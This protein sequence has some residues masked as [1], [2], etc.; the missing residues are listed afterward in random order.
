[1][2][3]TKHE[4]NS[5]RV[6]Y[7]LSRFPKLTETFILYEILE[8]Q[9]QDGDV[10]VHAMV[11]EH[12]DAIHPEARRM[13]PG[14]DYPRAARLL[15]SQIEWMARRPLEYLGLWVSAVL[16]NLRSP[17]FLLRA[18]ATV[19]I[20]AYFASRMSNVRVAHVHAHW[21]THS[22]LAGLVAA[23]LLDVPFSF[24][25]H[26]HDI[27]VNRTM[28]RRKVASAAFVVTISEYN[29]RF[30]QELYPDLSAKVVVVHCGVDVDELT[31]PA[32]DSRHQDDLFRVVCVASLQ[33]QKGHRVL[34]DAI[35]QLRDSGVRAELALIGDGPEAPALRRQ[36]A[37]LGLDQIVRFAGPLARPQVLQELRRSDLMVLASIPI[38]SG[39]MEGIPVALMEGMAMGLPVVATNISGVPELIADGVSGRLVPPGDVGALAGAIRELATEPETARRMGVAARAAV[40]TGFDLRQTAAELKH[41]FHHA[42]DTA[43]AQG[44]GNSTPQPES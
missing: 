42:A 13:L 15:A 1:M 14:V 33:K 27:Y 7:V 43:S 16:D 35:S 17:R 25:A 34:I 29:H 37:E 20:G 40:E 3:L 10:R 23:R 41:L 6:G 8:L 21:A 44:G 5:L 32:P 28:L 19:P 38:E 31:P 39:K 2:P 4:E 9:R 36:V 30:L 12:E 11:R 24:T 26:A 18:L 22:A